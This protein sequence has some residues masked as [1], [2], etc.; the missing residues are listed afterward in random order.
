VHGLIA[1]TILAQF[2]VREVARFPYLLGTG[3]TV[4]ALML[5][6]LLSRRWLAPV[7]LM[8]ALAPLYVAAN[9]LLFRRTQL[10]VPM[11]TPLLT[12]AVGALLAVIFRVALPRFPQH[13]TEGP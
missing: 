5:T 13:R 1:N 2:P 11:V 8:V 3:L 10:L 7:M 9:F 12:A 6:V 4:I